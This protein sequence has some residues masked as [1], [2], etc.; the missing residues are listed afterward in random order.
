MT[1]CRTG[2]VLAGGG[3]HLHDRSGGGLLCDADSRLLAREPRTQVGLEPR[4]FYNVVEFMM[5][6]VDK[7]VRASPLLF[8]W[9]LASGSPATA[10][11]AHGV[12]I[13]LYSAPTSSPGDYSPGRGCEDA[14]QP[15]RQGDGRGTGRRCATLHHIITLGSPAHAARVVTTPP[16]TNGGQSPLAWRLAPTH[17]RTF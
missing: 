3:L 16:E 15:I 12:C 5:H 11:S 4:K 7:R 14:P 6:D 2:N 1:R 13:D 8:T 17:R 10:R 9:H